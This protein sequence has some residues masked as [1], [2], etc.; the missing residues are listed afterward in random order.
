MKMLRLILA[1]GGVYSCRMIKC[2]YNVD[3]HIEN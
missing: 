2:K 3:I 1:I